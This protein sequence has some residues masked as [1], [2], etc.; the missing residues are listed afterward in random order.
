MKC[1]N[2]YCNY[3]E[4]KFAV[5]YDSPGSYWEPPYFEVDCSYNGP[6][7]PD[8]ADAYWGEDE[9]DE[10]CPY[11]EQGENSEMRKAREDAEAE[12]KYEAWLESKEFEKR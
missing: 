9:K 11:F 3:E 10:L 12:A 1:K 7:N 6:E 5:I 8:Y 2:V 4:C